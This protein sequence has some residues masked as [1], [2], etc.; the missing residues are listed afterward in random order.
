[1]LGADEIIRLLRLERLPGEGGL[2]RE[3]YRSSLIIPAGE[4]PSVYGGDR[5][6]GT[7]IYYLLT[8]DAHSA[9]HRLPGDEIYHFYYGDPVELLMLHAD[10]SGEGVEI[11]G[12]PSRGMRPQV[13]VPGGSWQGARLS[14]GGSVA[15]MGTTMSPGFEFA[16]YREADRADLVSRFPDHAEIIAALTPR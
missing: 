7:A 13:I 8:P 9:L 2:Y 4:L 14:P 11:G 10:G 5:A 3:T 6:A 16:D 1:M 12:D 15:L